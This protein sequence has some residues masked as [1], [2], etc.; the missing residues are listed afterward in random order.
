MSWHAQMWLGAGIGLTV[1]FVCLFLMAEIA[2]TMETP[3]LYH[4]RREQDE[5]KVPVLVVLGIIAF[6]AMVVAMGTLTAVTGNI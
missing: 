6:F 4:G 2:S 3:D 5:W 1:T